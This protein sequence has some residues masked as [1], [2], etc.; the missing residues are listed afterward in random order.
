MKKLKVKILDQYTLSLK[1]DGKA[2][3]II[4]LK[5]LME[6]DITPI[7]EAIEAGKDAIYN[8]KLNRTRES[9]KKDYEISI[10]KK[11]IEY[12]KKIYELTNEFNDKT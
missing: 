8:D 5:E 9:L 10:E 1:E 3:D 6:I 12:M 7:L 2:G 4:D 11:E